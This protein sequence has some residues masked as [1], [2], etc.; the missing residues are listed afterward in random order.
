M[1]FK[2][3]KKN[4]GCVMSNRDTVVIKTSN[5]YNKRQFISELLKIVSK[6]LTETEHIFMVNLLLL[7]NSKFDT[8]IR[9]ILLSSEPYKNLPN[10]NSLISVCLT[11]LRY[12]TYLGA[13][14]LSY[15]SRGEYAV[16]PSLAK[17]LSLLQDKPI[18]QVVLELKYDPHVI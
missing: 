16:N 13:P 9:K 14:I 11:R 5:T 10:A 18:T 1:T 7:S 12:K 4:K 6:S 8:K 15:V 17:H 2:T 3:E